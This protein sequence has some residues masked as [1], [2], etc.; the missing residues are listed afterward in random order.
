MKPLNVES[1]IYDQEPMTTERIDSDSWS[2]QEGG[3]GDDEDCKE[4]YKMHG[5]A[6]KCVK[7]F[8]KKDLAMEDSGDEEPKGDRPDKDGKRK[9]GNLCI[10]KLC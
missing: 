1:Q 10:R 3:C 9:E 4:D 5:I 2:S 6:S 7:D 8:G